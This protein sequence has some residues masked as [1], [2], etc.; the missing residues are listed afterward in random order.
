MWRSTALS[1]ETFFR[2]L[3][4]GRDLTARA[5][6]HMALLSETQGGGKSTRGVEPKIDH[7][8]CETE[9]E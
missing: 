7:Y 1:R 3:I 6:A 9:E 8:S 5:L 2:N 4:L